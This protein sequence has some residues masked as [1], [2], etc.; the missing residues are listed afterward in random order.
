MIILTVL[1]AVCAA[2][3]YAVSAAFEHQAARREPQHGMADPRLL[4]RLM[5]RRRWLAGAGAD[6][7]GA[8]L[9]A[10]ALALG[11][12]ALVQPILIGGLI[13]ALPIEAALNRRRVR[14]RELTAVIVSGVGL[15]VLLGIASPSPGASV[16]DP[17][18]ETEVVGV[19]AAVLI[20][21]LFAWRRPG[22]ARSVVLGVATGALLGLGAALLKVTLNHLAD[23]SVH[24]LRTWE[25]YA[26]ILVEL[27]ALAL[28]Q[29]AF[30]AG[31]LAGALTGVTLTD[32]VV[33]TTIAVSAF[34]EH[35]AL[36]GART[37]AAIMAALVTAWGVWL[38]SSAWATRR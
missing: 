17:E 37:V 7:G 1:V 2:F 14:R 8:C 19:A 25:L 36:G 26:L 23:D 35:L 3:L 24:I 31:R 38:V 33:A 11:P 18:L 10:L 32:P 30:Q 29:N 15:A 5:R 21:L 9:Q 20:L 16:G 27:A 28:N 22:V 12:L 6:F 4:L 13:M 34:Q